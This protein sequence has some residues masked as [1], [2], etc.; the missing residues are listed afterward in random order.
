MPNQAR[1]L[2][3]GRLGH[4]GGAVPVGRDRL[5]G[6][7]KGV[8]RPGGEGPAGAAVGDHVQQASGGG[9]H[10]R[11][12]RE[13][14]LDRDQA[15][16]LVPAGHDQHGRPPVAAGQL[17][18][19][20]LGVP[21]DPAGHA[22]LAGQAAQ[23]GLLGALPATRRHRAAAGPAV[24]RARAARATSAPFCRSRRPTNSSSSPGLAVR[25]GGEGEV[26]VGMGATVTGG[27]RPGAKAAT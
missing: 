4:P 23:G 7:G 13:L 8:G 1:R 17:G 2:L 21:A 3:P 5:D 27:A 11:G 9:G 16:T 15:Q 12:A 22:P 14:A 18:L 10:H 6:P 25:A 20:E 24:S 19:G 26:V